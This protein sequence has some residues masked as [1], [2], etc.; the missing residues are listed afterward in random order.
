MKYT[1]IFS[2]F[3][4]ILCGIFIG[5]ENP[6]IIEKP[7]KSVKSFFNKDE[8]NYLANNKDQLNIKKNDNDF[9]ANSFD[10]EI[11]KIKSYD[12]K[13]AG[14]FFN[15]KKELKV[16]SQ[17]GEIIEKKIKRKINLPSDFTLESD[18]GVRSVI[19]YKEN[20][21]GLISRK[22]DNCYFSS[23]IN[24]KNKKKIFDTKCLPER[25]SVNFAGLGGAFQN[26]NESLLIS[27]GTP[28]HESEKIDGLAQN[29]E[30]FYGKMLLISTDKIDREKYLKEIFSK[31]H[32]NPQGL[33]QVDGILFSTEHGP[34]GGDEI[35][36]IEKNKNYGWPI[37][38]LGTRYGGKSFNYKLNEKFKSPV[39]S[40][41]PSIAPSALSNCPNNLSNYYNEFICLI[42]LTLR[43]MS[44]VVY[45]I[46]KKTMKLFSY[47]KINLNK[48]M[49]HFGVNPETDLFTENDDSFYFSSDND[50]I[51]KAKFKNF[52]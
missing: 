10:L 16:F 9:F 25:E 47:E 24:I 8:S 46:D 7:K 12:G 43:E 48:R 30:Y 1:K 34:Q 42:G 31:G 18:G 41:S 27:I 36:I 19:Y 32:R 33:A 15:K 3:F 4:L 23:L 39:F 21:F 29:D 51:Y 2:Y 13:T 11:K 26:L 20:Y 45:L 49:R 35:N 28:T 22:K 38:S 44:L 37:V 52:R 17:N 50:G 6:E 5:Y 40:F 14:L